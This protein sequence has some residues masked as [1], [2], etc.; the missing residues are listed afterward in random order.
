MVSEDLFDVEALG[1]LFALL[2][3]LFP[4]IEVEASAMK[5]FIKHMKLAKHNICTRFYI[6]NLELCSPAPN[7]V[8]IYNID[9]VASASPISQSYLHPQHI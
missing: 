5:K 4:P 9:Q 1:E 3:H 2:E 8:R 7:Y 6:A